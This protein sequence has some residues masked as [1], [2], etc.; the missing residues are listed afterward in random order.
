MTSRV[1]AVSVTEYEQWIARRKADIKAAEQAAAQQRKQIAGS[2]AN[3][4]P[5]GPSQPGQNPAQP[6][7]TTQP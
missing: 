6:N 5:G 2:T 7:L 4:Q 3:T 1:R